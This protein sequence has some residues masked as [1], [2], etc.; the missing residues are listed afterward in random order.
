M[1]IG[2]SLSNN[3]GLA[4][5]QDVVSVAARAEELGYD[6]VW[7]SDHVFN[8]SYVYEFGCNRFYPYPS[9]LLQSGGRTERTWQRSR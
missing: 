2:F 4:N 5:V 7:A 6:S 8:V 9:P 1:N 3:Q